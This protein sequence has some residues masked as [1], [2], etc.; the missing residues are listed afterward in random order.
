M[1]K[2]GRSAGLQESPDKLQGGEH[3]LSPPSPSSS[4]APASSPLPS[5]CYHCWQGSSE[6]VRGPKNFSII[7]AYLWLAVNPEVKTKEILAL[8]SFLFS[9]SAVSGSFPQPCALQSSKQVICIYS[10]PSMTRNHVRLPEHKERQG[11]LPDAEDLHGCG[12]H[13]V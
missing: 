13:K 5:L 6:E 10:N 1:L 2:V 7:T 12:G 8:L 3:R 11:T 4:P 9:L